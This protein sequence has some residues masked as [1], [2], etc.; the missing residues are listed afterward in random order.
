MDESLEALKADLERFGEANDAAT[1][2]RPRHMLNITRDTGEFLGVL[3]RAT[4]ARCVLEIGTSN[5]YS[6]LWLAEAARAIGGTV[7]TIELAEHKVGLASANFKRSGLSQFIK[8][9][10][11]NAGRFL[12]QSDPSAYDFIFLD[13]ERTEYSGWWPHLRRV[14][15]PG[16]LLITDNATSHEKELVP[17]VA[18]VTADPEFAT[19]LVPVG[20]GEFLAVKNSS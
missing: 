13:S 20:N 7:T 19:C 5:G 14:L 16:G 10:H 1:T 15:R 3:V 9:V 12:K 4:T 18:V 17:F 11:D 6:T 8:L 2:E